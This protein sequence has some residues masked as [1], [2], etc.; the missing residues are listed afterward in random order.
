LLAI[1][2]FFKANEK[3]FL[4]YNKV[5]NPEIQQIYRDLYT[6]FLK[7]LTPQ[8]HPILFAV[9]GSPGFG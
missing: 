2:H 1:A 3:E 7:D 6:E 4:Q 9:G 8:E 5:E